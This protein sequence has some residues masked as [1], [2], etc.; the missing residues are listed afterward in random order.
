MIIPVVQCPVRML[1]QSV[2]GSSA[3]LSFLWPI[4][5]WTFPE[6][7]RTQSFHLILRQ[8]GLW[9][10][11]VGLQTWGDLTELG[12]IRKCIP[13]LSNLLFVPLPSKMCEVTRWEK[14]RTPSAVFH[15][16]VSHDNPSCAVSCQN[17]IAVS[18]RKPMLSF[19]SPILVWTFPV[20]QRTQ[21]FHL[22]LR[23]PELWRSSVG[24]QTWGDLTELGKIRKCIPGL[25]NLLFV[26]LPSKMCE[27]TRWEKSRTPS[28]V[29]HV[30]VSHD[31]AICAVACQNAIA[32]STRKPMLS[33]L[34]PILVWTF[35]VGQRT[36]SFHLI[37][38]QPGLWRSSV[39]L[40][41]RGDL[42]E[43]GKIRKLIAG[44][45]NLLFV[46][47]ASKMCEVTRWEK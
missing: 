29:F 46:P 30:A 4:L 2:Q 11:S 42:T 47:L 18:T 12:K 36:Q 1:L 6:G 43:L 32:V 40:Q 25:S 33:F 7:Q 20:G 22:I 27:V 28:A 19:L 44:L 16:A 39:G 38:R 45:S 10:S 3:M 37:L 8:P 23:Q 26:P 17:A 34:S 31:N 15:V 9:S 21:S 35:P 14:S 41:T 24:L 5:V 13:G